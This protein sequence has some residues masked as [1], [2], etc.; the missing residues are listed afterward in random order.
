MFHA[1]PYLTAG[2][3]LYAQAAYLFRKEL[4]NRTKAIYVRSTRTDGR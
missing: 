3:A 1:L 2:V 4:F